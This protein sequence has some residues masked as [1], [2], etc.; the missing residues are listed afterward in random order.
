[1]DREYTVAVFPGKPG[2]KRAYLRDYNPA[3]PG[4]CLHTIVATSGREAKSLAIAACRMG[5]HR[6]PI[7]EKDGKH[8]YP[9]ALMDDDLDEDEYGICTGQEKSLDAWADDCGKQLDGSCTQGGTEYCQYHCPF[10]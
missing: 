8:H 5:L 10:G 1:M 3:W 7:G 6:I 4:C 2:G 9:G